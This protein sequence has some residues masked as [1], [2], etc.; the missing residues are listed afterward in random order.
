M[1]RRLIEN[2]RDDARIL[3]SGEERDRKASQVLESHGVLTDA[4]LLGV[5]QPPGLGLSNQVRTSDGAVAETS[6]RGLISPVD[7]RGVLNAI[8]KFTGMTNPVEQRLP[9]IH[10]LYKGVRELR[11]IE[12]VR[13]GGDPMRESKLRAAGYEL[14]VR[15]VA[16]PTI[17]RERRTSALGLP[18]LV[19]VSDSGR[20]PR[21]SDFVMDRR[22]LSREA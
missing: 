13:M 16:A 19:Q 5:R 20:L 10:S 17:L 14:R 3:S 11:E 8:P 15:C 9:D 12:M 22:E 6:S 2:T 7:I 18:V 4:D 21:C 1:V